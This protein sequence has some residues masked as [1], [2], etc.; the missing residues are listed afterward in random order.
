M[1]LIKV[2]NYFNYFIGNPANIQDRMNYR[3]NPLDTSQK[4][5]NPY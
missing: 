4:F 3:N 2:S 1:T 5:D